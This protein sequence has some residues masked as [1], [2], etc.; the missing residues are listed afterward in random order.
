MTRDQIKRLID[1]ETEAANNL[2]KK[3]Q[4]IR[5]SWVS[6]ELSLMLAEIEQLKKQLGE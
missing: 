2:S 1:Q 4:G 6:C 5:P 3:Y